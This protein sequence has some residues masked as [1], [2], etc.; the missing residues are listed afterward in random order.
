MRKFW[1]HC[2]VVMLHRLAHSS[3]DAGAICSL[4][5]SRNSGDS[6]TSSA[7]V[8]SMPRGVGEDRENINGNKNTIKTNGADSSELRSLYSAMKSFHSQ[9]RLI[10]SCLFLTL[11]TYSS[12]GSAFSGLQANEREV[13]WRPRI[14]GLY[15]SNL[16]N[17]V[18]VVI[19]LCPPP[20]PFRHVRD[21][22]CNTRKGV[23]IPSRTPIC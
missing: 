13:G 8:E 20:L 9:T 10:S 2:G 23:W 22:K 21:S 16:P 1:H 11:S 6:T 14:I 5:F 3:A 17:P 4:A 18:V 15:N 7:L 19:P 12:P